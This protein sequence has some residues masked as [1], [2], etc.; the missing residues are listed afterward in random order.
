VSAAQ[1]MA[2][3]REWV[4]RAAALRDARAL[5]DTRGGAQDRAHRQAVLLV[6]VA[7][8]T[9][10]PAEALPPGEGAAVELGLYR[11]AAWWAFMSQQPAGGGPGPE[12]PAMWSAHPPERL[13]AHAGD[14]ERLAAVKASL[15]GTGP[16]SLETN[17][18]QVEQ[19]RVFLTA[20]LEELDAPRRRVARVLAQRWSRLAVIGLVLVM[21]GLGV[22]KLALGPNLA[23]GKPFRTSSTF[24]DCGSACDGLMF[25]TQNQNNPWVELDLGAPKKIRRLEV[26]N[27]QDCCGDRAVPLVAEVSLDAALWTEVGRRTEEFSTWTVK[28]PPRMARYVRFRVLKATAMHFRDVAVR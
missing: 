27:R 17:R 3:F 16:V 28:F 9:R 20:F 19:V 15:L 12:L 26:T 23:A 13:Q 10:E 25:H 8:R 5:L 1:K 18:R 7:R 11:E 4:F 2:R 6:E 22:R 14:A 21:A 24:A